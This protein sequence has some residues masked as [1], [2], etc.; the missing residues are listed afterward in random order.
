MGA[1]YATDAQSPG[2]KEEIGPMLK[3]LAVY[4]TVLT[5]VMLPGA[6]LA[7]DDE[8]AGN[9]DD[10]A[11]VQEQNSGFRLLDE[12]AVIAI[13]GAF[14]AALVIM[15]GGKAIARIGGGAVESMARQP[16]V[17]GQINVAMI[18]TAAMVEGATM[19]AIV[20]CLLTVV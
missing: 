13:A 16:E 15:G 4:V 11:Q 17:A 9:A 6:A 14:G 2:V 1:G 3:K 7:A 12:Q 8:A 19:F 18:I 10:G 5:I 20:V